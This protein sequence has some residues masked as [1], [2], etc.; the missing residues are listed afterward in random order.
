M[1]LIEQYQNRT[2]MNVKEN[3][4]FSACSVLNDVLIAPVI[5]G[6]LAKKKEKVRR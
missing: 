1:R 2:G 4:G 5:N 3:K 6:A